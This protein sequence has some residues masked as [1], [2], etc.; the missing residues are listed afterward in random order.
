MQARLWLSSALDDLLQLKE[1]FSLTPVG[2][3]LDGNFR[4]IEQMVELQRYPAGQRWLSTCK[5]RIYAPSDYLS[6]WR[7][8]FANQ[9]GFTFIPGGESCL[10]IDGEA[11]TVVRDGLSP[12]GVRAWLRTE[13]L[14]QK[15]LAEWLG[16]TPSRLS[17][18]L[19]GRQPFSAELA[20]QVQSLMDHPGSIQ[21][22]P[23]LA[24]GLST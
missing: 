21:S 3:G 2:V 11:G 15:A 19:T 6:R 7:C 18:Q 22:S 5:L 1:A 4:D 20:N 12:E 9:L 23:S 10:H 17:R 14:T 24:S 16:W 8:W 13:G